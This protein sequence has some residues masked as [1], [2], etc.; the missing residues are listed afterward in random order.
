MKQVFFTIIIFFIA[1]YIT[2]AQDS[3][4]IKITVGSVSFVATT[5]DNATT[6]AFIALLPMTINMNELNGNEKYHFLSEN[7]PSSPERP[8]TIHAG[9]MMLY[10]T[11]GIVLFY[12]TFSTSYSYSKIG[13]M[14][15]TNGLKAALGPANVTVTFELAQGSTGIDKEEQNNS[16]ILR[17]NDGFL[18]Y[19]GCVDRISIIDINGRTLSCTTSNIIDTQTFPK[20][21]Y[22]LKI[23][24]RNRIKTI[25]VKF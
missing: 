4:K 13:Y 9:D 25:K 12:E 24:E 15:D 3:A 21:I 17:S 2:N 5:Y 10:G 16:K 11:N 8:S 20:G 7:L 18:H 22:I 19:T 14:D 1:M 6:K 23:E